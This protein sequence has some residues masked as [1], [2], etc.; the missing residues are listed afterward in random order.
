[1]DLKQM[2]DVQLAEASLVAV[3]DY[4]VSKVETTAIDA[5]MKA[6]GAERMRAALAEIGERRDALRLDAQ[7][8]SR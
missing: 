2:T 7:E 5:E 1:M 3:K 8:E 6:R 4:P